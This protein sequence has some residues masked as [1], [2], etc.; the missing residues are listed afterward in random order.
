MLACINMQAETRTFS[1][2]FRIGMWWRVFYG[3][4][5]FSAGVA[6]LMVASSDLPSLF[7]VI[8]RGE[9][10]EDPND[11]FIRSLGLLFSH[12]PL[13]S[14]AFIAYYL[15]V[16]GAADVFLSVNILRYKLWAYPAAFVFVGFFTLYEIFR[17]IHTHSLFLVFIIFVDIFILWLIW[18]EYGIL[19]QVKMSIENNES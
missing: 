12:V 2:F 3:S 8:S 17:V 4:L 6:L 5:K 9:L 16:W 13:N 18:R 19:K 11:L 7:K 10:I 14:V 15:L 1:L